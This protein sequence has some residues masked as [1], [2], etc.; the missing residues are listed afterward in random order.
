MLL[1][2]EEDQ[3]EDAPHIVDEIRI[4]E[5][6]RPAF[7]R[8]REGSQHQDSGVLRQE[9]LKRMTL[10]YQLLTLNCQLSTLNYHLSTILHLFLDLLGEQLDVGLQ[11]VDTPFI[12]TSP[13]DDKIRKLLGGLDKLLVHGLH[14]VFIVV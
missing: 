7:L 14:I 8:W 9:R 2:V 4:I 6:H 1:V 3:A 11:D 5:L 10:N 12:L 13:G